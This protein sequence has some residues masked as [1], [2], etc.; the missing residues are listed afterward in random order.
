MRIQQLETSASLVG[1]AAADP[2][3]AGPS[4]GAAPYLDYVLHLPCAV[5]RGQSALSSVGAPCTG[6]RTR[7]VPLVRGCCVRGLLPARVRSGQMAQAPGAEEGEPPQETTS[8]PLFPTSEPTEDPPPAMPSRVGSALLS[9][10][11]PAGDD[12][13]PPSMPAEST[14][15]LLAGKSEPEPEPGAALRPAPM[16]TRAAEGAK[17]YKGDII[18]VDT[19]DGMERCA[20]ILGKPESGNPGEMMVKF[21]DGVIQDWDIAEFVK[22]PPAAGPVVFTHHGPNIRLGWERREIRA[23]IATINSEPIDPNGRVVTILRGESEKGAG[24][25]WEGTPV[26]VPKFRKVYESAVCGEP[27]SAGQHCKQSVF[28]PAYPPAE[29]SCHWSEPDLMFAHQLCLVDHDHQ[30]WR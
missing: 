24:G 29:H 15:N 21:A 4:C 27:L 10:S 19:E 20:L 3:G 17:F 12:D 23:P 8:A 5:C 28:A 16:L 6:T 1:T 30:M 14:A 2:G 18:D 22:L 13:P 26:N 7:T 11:R 9:S 25:A